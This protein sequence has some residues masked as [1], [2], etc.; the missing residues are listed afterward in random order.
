LTDRDA[1]FLT[2]GKRRG[3]KRKKCLSFLVKGTT[4]L[5]IAGA[6]QIGEKA[7]VGFAAGKI[8]TGPH[9]QRL[10]AGESKLFTIRLEARNGQKAQLK[11]RRLVGQSFP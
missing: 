7:L 9:T 10:I 8:T 3:R 1:Q 6:N 11:Q 2:R 4:A 5:E